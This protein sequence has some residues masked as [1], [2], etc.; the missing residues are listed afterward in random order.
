MQV[1]L[2]ISFQNMASSDGIEARVR[3]RVARLERF[4]HE[5][6]SCRVAIEAPHKQPHSSTVGITIDIHVPG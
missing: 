5:I 3:E 2:K 1:P 4:S 6:V